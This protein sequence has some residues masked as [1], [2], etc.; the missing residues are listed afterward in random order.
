[1]KRLVVAAVVGAAVLLVPAAPAVAK[2]DP[3]KALKARF[4]AGKGVKVSNLMKISTGGEVWA[5]MREVGSVGFGRSGVATTDIQDKPQYSKAF[6]DMLPEA[7][8]EELRKTVGITRTIS[9]SR[10]AYI[11]GARVKNYLPEGKTWVRRFSGTPVPGSLLVN[12]FEPRTLD[13]IIDR[14]GSRQGSV[15]KGWIASS[16]LA[17]ISPSFRASFGSGAKTRDGKAAKVNY[18]VWLDARGLVKRVYATMT[19][20][21]VDTP[22][23]YASDGRVSGWG[24]KVVIS[25]PPAGEVIDEGQLA[26]GALDDPGP[27]QLD[28]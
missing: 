23:T 22:I 10:Y 19:V 25:A 15:L 27:V 20:H 24:G 28:F 8:R 14:A 3:V 11:S 12:P 6:L 9:T 2:A 21:I 4:A 18:I 1:M 13:K 7:D 16:S 26:D 5:T 17:K